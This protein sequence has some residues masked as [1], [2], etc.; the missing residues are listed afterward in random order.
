MKT[1]R[2]VIAATVLLELSPVLFAVPGIFVYQLGDVD[3]FTYNG[4]SD[5]PAVDPDWLA[6]IQDTFVWPMSGFDDSVY[7]NI[8]RPFTFFYELGPEEEIVS[9]TLDV[10][11]KA[12]NADVSTDAIL[13]ELTEN[14]FTF[15]E[16]GW[17][18]ISSSST[19]IR[20]LDLSNVMGNNFLPE[21]QDGQLNVL[22]VDD[23]GIDYATLTVE[24]VPEPGTIFLLGLGGLSLV[25]KRV[26]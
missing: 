22:I 7:Q 3:D 13:L 8:V 18:P 20:T 5:W 21:M 6:S 4:S 15:A 19:Q 10:A 14:L 2:F 17:L 16:L 26:G 25:R 11:V 9:A 23:T 24:V 1:M 12:I